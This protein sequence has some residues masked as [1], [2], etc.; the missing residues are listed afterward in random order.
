VEVFRLQELLSRLEQRSQEIRAFEVVSG[1]TFKAGLIAF[2][3]G[4]T[5][6]PN[7]ITHPNKDVLC[8]VLRGRGRLRA[9]GV[10]TPLEAGMLCHVPA[11]VPHD[12]AAAG[13]ELLLLYVLTGPP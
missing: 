8:Y 12:F 5:A 3:P 4:G 6:D 2:S 11:T 13:E 1:P 7:E 10:L 9:N